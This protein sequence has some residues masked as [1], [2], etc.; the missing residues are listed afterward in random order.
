M[1]KVLTEAEIEAFRRDGYLY[2]FDCM[3][4]AE[5]GGLYARLEAFERDIDADARTRLR[6]KAHLGFPWMVELARRPAILDVVEDLIGPDILLYLSA[7]WSKPA[8]DPGFVS[9]HQDSA[10][11]GIAPHDEVTVWFAFS[12]S[13]VKSGCVRVIPGTHRA[14]LGHVD[15]GVESNLLSRHQQVDGTVD[16]SRAV[17]LTLEPGEFSLHH[18]QIVH[19]SQPNR[20]ERRRIGLSLRYVAAH[21]R[22][23][24][25]K[26]DSATLVRG[27]NT[28]GNFELEPRP[29]KDFDPAVLAVRER[30]KEQQA[31]FLYRSLEGP[32]T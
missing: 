17:A 2:P 28:H 16:T 25:G 8:G 10:Y 12:D 20:T 4:P 27:E 30:L 31:A 24:A 15:T 18:V 1:A 6:V 22:Q 14:L 32:D 3:T 5:A 9:W 19:G 7:L 11:Y 21:V 13:T 29:A 23:I 26:A